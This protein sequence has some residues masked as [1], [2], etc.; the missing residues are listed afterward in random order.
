MP[1][2]TSGDPTAPVHPIIVESSW[3]GNG[4]IGVYWVEANI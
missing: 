2:Y 3:H 1:I 4:A